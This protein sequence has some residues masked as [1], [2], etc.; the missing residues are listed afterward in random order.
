MHG[1]VEGIVLEL[2]QN[3]FER[4]EDNWLLRVSVEHSFFFEPRQTL[5]V[6]FFD[7]FLHHV[8]GILVGDEFRQIGLVDHIVRH[9]FA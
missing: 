7:D 1:H 3:R 4:G 6:S 2:L 8:I 9:L 5:A